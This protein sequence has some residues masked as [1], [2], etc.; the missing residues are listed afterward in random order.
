[1]NV[2]FSSTRL[3]RTRRPPLGC[4]A[5]AS[6][7]SVQF[8]DALTHHLEPVKLDR[9]AQYRHTLSASYKGSSS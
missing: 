1:M 4:R 3:Q 6:P 7:F 5:P 2:Y 9:L 8:L